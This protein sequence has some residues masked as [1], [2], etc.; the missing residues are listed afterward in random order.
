MSVTG[1]VSTELR[2]ASVFSDQE[3]WNRVLC[4]IA[5]PWAWCGALPAVQKEPHQRILDLPHIPRCFPLVQLIKPFSCSEEALTVSCTKA[6]QKLAT[7]LY[8]ETTGPY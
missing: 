8:L 2:Q 3:L 4:Y 5:L 7:E 1:P 6:S